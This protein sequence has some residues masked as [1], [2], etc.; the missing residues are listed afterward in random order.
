MNSV[1]VLRQIL[2]VGSMLLFF[3]FNLGI[4]SELPL[5]YVP[6][7]KKIE[8]NGRGI[9]IK[10]SLA[11]LFNRDGFELCDYFHF[12]PR[13][14]VLDAWL[15]VRRT[16]ENCVWSP[17]SVFSSDYG[18]LI[19]R[20]SGEHRNDIDTVLCCAFSRPDLVGYLPHHLCEM[21][22]FKLKIREDG[23]HERIL[24]ENKICEQCWNVPNKKKYPKE[25]SQEDYVAL[26]D[27]F[28]KSMGCGYKI[29][30]QISP[31]YLFSFAIDFVKYLLHDKRLKTISAFK[32]DR[33]AIDLLFKDEKNFLEGYRTGTIKN[34]KLCDGQV[35]PMFVIYVDF[36]NDSIFTRNR[37]LD[38]VI[39]ALI[40]RYGKGKY[41]NKKDNGTIEFAL[42]K[43]EGDVGNYTP[44]LNKKINDLIY[45]AGG[46]YNPKEDYKLLI[47]NGWLP[48]NTVYTDD[49]V[50]VKGYEYEYVSTEGWSKDRKEKRYGT[51]IYNSLTL[52]KHKLLQLA[53]KLEEKREG[54]FAAG[55]D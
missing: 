43:K 30:L 52:L 18:P 16:S 9:P 45:I 21:L 55:G 7:E 13:L 12:R 4:T 37:I 8:N 29:H 40:E 32:F 44:R 35:S 49:F 53:E 34:Y 41:I 2:S 10:A 36:Y 3:C 31:K 42:I 15:V 39:D 22:A 28:I 24:R 47:K 23:D 17:K 51:P 26:R 33:L 1:K 19:G 50:F 11:P 46:D 54:A 38:G 25:F 14:S 20:T 5:V 27:E 6:E 48:K